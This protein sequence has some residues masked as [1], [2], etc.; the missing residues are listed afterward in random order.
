MTRQKSCLGKGAVYSP[1]RMVWLPAAVEKFCDCALLFVLLVGLCVGVVRVVC[2]EGEEL[3]TRME[4]GRLESELDGGEEVGEGM[5]VGVGIGTGMTVIS[6]RME[7]SG[8]VVGIPIGLVSEGTGE[9]SPELVTSDP[10]KAGVNTRPAD[11]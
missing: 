8:D 2:V 1:T 5:G 6:L 3:A 7:G 9:S 10:V 11:P 4:V